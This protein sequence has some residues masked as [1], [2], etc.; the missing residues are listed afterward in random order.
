MAILLVYWAATGNNPILCCT[1]VKVFQNSEAGLFTSRKKKCCSC[2]PDGAFRLSKSAHWQGWPLGLFNG[3]LPRCRLIYCWHAIEPADSPFGPN[4]RRALCCGGS[5]W[6]Y[7]NSS[8]SVLEA[9]DTGNFD[10]DMT[11]NMFHWGQSVLY[12]ISFEWVR[13]IPLSRV[14]VCGTR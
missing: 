14:A 9:G 8:Y 2:I 1:D 10:P 3:S 13:G 12:G 7:C 5:W 6:P 4:A 11:I